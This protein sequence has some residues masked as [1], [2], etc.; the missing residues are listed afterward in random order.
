MWEL[1]FDPS[2]L[3]FSVCLS[4]MFL[5]GIIEM[6]LLICGLS[7]Q[8]FLEQFLP[9]GLGDAT[10]ELPLDNHTSFLVQTLDW[11]YIGRIPILVWF[12]IFLAVYSLSGFVLQ[13]IFYSI[14][15]YFIPLLWV[16]ILVLFICMPI[17]RISAKV[18]SNV[19][20][21]DETI[22][23]NSEEL[24]GLKAE[25][26]LGTARQ[27][28]PA[29]AKLK[30]RYGQTHYVLVEPEQDLEFN[31]GDKVILT[32]RTKKGFHAIPQ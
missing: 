10:P 7:S 16:A 25:I 9:D 31:A 3:V 14:F 6:I 2:N 5:I 12:I 18:I 17:V 8:S 27:N 30:D 28:Y 1:F 20:P 32:E 13:T 22:A 23:I 11:L 15:D 4:L 21:N 29:Q 24:I 26:I 19:M